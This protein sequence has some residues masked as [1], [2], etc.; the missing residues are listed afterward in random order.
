MNKEEFAPLLNNPEVQAAGLA[1]LEDARVK[2]AEKVGKGCRAGNP[3]E[4]IGS[5]R[6][7]LALNRPAESKALFSLL[8]QGNNTTPG[9]WIGLGKSQLMLK[10][11]EAA[12]D[13]LNRA[14]ELAPNNLL[15]W[16]S[17]ASA[18]KYAKQPDEQKKAEEKVLKLIEQ[19][20]AEQPEEDPE[21]EPEEE[22]T[23]T[24]L[25]DT[26]IPE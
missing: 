5:S 13:S 22:A 18:C 12:M 25:L 23:S 15:A 21:P 4:L 19:Q 20:K 2:Y 10:E 6:I 7:F 24:S 16:A 1:K 11:F 17:Y 8:V 9:A 3:A 26:Q 14:T